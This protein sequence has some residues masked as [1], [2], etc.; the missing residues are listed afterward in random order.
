MVAKTC[1]WLHGLANRTIA[2]PTIG[3][4]PPAG[5]LQSSNFGCL[6]VN[7]NVWNVCPVHGE[8]WCSKKEATYTYVHRTQ[9]DQIISSLKHFPNTPDAFVS[10]DLWLFVLHTCVQMQTS[11]RCPRNSERYW[12][13][14]AHACHAVSTLLSHSGVSLPLSS[15]WAWSLASVHHNK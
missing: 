15:G 7:C 13:G 3:R 8:E 12:L 4:A 5:L 11:T 1:L 2:P 14:P 10:Y 6:P 9:C